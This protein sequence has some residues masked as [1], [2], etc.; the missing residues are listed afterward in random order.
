M[1]V[2][3]LEHR[4]ALEQRVTE[5]LR[6][7]L[8]GAG[9]V[10]DT[11][12]CAVISSF[13]KIEDVRRNLHA[14]YAQTRPFDRVVVVDNCSSDGSADMV[15]SEFP[16]V[17][18][19]VM[20]HTRFGACETFNIGFKRAG[21]DWIAILDDDVELCPE[22]LEK[23]LEKTASEP[24][25]T[26]FLSSRVVEPGMPEWF[27]EHPEVNRERYMSTFRGCA[28][29]A[30]GSVLERCRFYA[31]DF[32]IYGNERDLTARVLSAGCRV[33]Q[34][35]A[36][37]VKHGTPF[38]MKTGKRSLYFHVRNLWWT[39]AKHCAAWD[40]LGFLWAQVRKAAVR[41]PAD[42]RSDA[43][44]TIGFARTVRETPGGL[45]VVV[46]ATLAALLGLPRQLRKRRVVRA[47]DFSLPDR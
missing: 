11:T 36:V 25:T 44:G 29:L 19:V 14:V 18:L 24:P 30:R 43:V 33:L 46:R 39:L 8:P 1:T 16:D 10:R 40:I 31:E 4:P 28:T 2:E 9:T 27:L 35:P 3:V 45:Q 37:T 41:D 17:D 34:Y 38:G 7:A 42:D 26:A 15:R 20:P 22:W 12:A 5:A 32:F 13:N 21:T 6:R 47:V 23:M